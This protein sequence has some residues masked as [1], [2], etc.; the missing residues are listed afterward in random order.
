MGV[1]W[2][3]PSHKQPS[4]VCLPATLSHSHLSR[5]PEEGGG[6]SMADGTATGLV[7]ARQLQE[8]AARLRA[9]AEA[10][11]RA[12]GTFWGVL[13]GARCHP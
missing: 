13:S 5:A 10:R 7:S 6:S 11:R 3:T 9:E 8:E 2:D 12:G 4:I 1:V